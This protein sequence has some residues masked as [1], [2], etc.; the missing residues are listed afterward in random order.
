MTFMPETPL[1]SIV[2]PAFNGA[3]VIEETLDSVCEQ[4]F[5]DFEVIIVDDGSTDDTAVVAR[6]FCEADERFTLIQQPN[7]GPSVALNTAIGHARGEWIAFLDHDDVWLPEKLA[8]QMELFREDPRAN[9]L[10]T[11]YYYWDGNHDFSAYY[12]Q[13][14]PLPEGD[15]TRKLVVACVYGTSAVMVRRETLQ[16]VGPFDP[17]LPF[18][19]DWDMWL[20]IAE[21]GMWAHGTHE[22]LARYRRWAGNM[23]NHKLKMAEGGV[24]VLEKNLCATQ[25]PELRPIYRHSLAFARGNL[26]LARARQLLESQPE[27]VPAAIWHA[28]RQHPRRLKWLMW[29][30]LVAWP[31]VLG[32]AAGARV[33]H[34]KLIQKF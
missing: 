19:Q 20:R 23:S 26:E 3:S 2:V 6:E 33:I 10:F 15:A 1:V 9:F 17:D 18:T 13:N 34:R 7:G 12:R 28:W 4:T 32:G 14:R 30:A 29:F 25:H 21:R 16:A 24:C 11:N 8:C 31:K 22:P 5:R 27:A